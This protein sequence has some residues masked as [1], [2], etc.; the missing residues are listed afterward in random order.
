MK[1]ENP[2]HNRPLLGG[3]KIVWPAFEILKL[4]L[5]TAP[6]ALLLCFFC[7]YLQYVFAN[8]HIVYYELSAAPHCEG[9]MCVFNA[10]ISFRY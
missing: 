4:V 1:E 10:P 7:V 2:N 8:E 3:I 5:Q 6:G 9:K